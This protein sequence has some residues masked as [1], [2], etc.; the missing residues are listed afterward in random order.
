MVAPWRTNASAVETKVYEGTITSSP[1]PTPVRIAAI[2]SASVH[3][4]VNRHL[5]KP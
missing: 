4:V 1:G 3:E 5:R 2:S